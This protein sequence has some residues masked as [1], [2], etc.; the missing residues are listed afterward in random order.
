[1]LQ[2]V[3]T[4]IVVRLSDSPVYNDATSVMGVDLD[5]VIRKSD[6]VVGAFLCTFVFLRVRATVREEGDV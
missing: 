5:I 4:I 3:V 1:M 6:S 2:V